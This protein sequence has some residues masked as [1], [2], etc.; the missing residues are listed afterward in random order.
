MKILKVDKITL[1]EDLRP[2]NL[3][4][5]SEGN[6]IGY[7]QSKYTCRV[8]FETGESFWV[9]LGEDLGI[10][11]KLI[12]K[13]EDYKYPNGLGRDMFLLAYIYPI[14][15][16]YF[17]MYGFEPKESD[18]RFAQEQARK[19]DSN[20]DKFLEDINNENTN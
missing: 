1:E 18:L 3:V 4:K 11:L 16:K 19:T 15:K 10:I 2:E 12:S 14:Y 6:T 5:D 9:P 7:K 17:I 8:Y 13:N 20:Y